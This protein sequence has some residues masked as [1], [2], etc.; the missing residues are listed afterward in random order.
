MVSLEDL[1]GF[2]SALPAQ[3]PGRGPGACFSRKAWRETGSLS[4]PTPPE[5]AFQA[6]AEGWS[7]VTLRRPSDPRRQQPGSSQ[8]AASPQ[9]ERESLRTE[10]G[11]GL[12]LSYPSHSGRTHTKP[13]LRE[14]RQPLLI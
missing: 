2:S 10:P 3:V 7:H 11:G 13:H 12:S 5:A 6:A 1:K 4:V 8:A 14:G 9:E